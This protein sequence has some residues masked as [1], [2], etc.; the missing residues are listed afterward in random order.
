MSN[1]LWH[2]RLFTPKRGENTMENKHVYRLQGLSCA[3]CAA[4]FEKN[5]KSIATV[6]DAEVNF[7]A[8][9]LTVIGEAS[10][11]ELEK[12]GAF[13][14]ITVIPE[15]ERKEQKAEPFWKKKTNVI[16]MISALFLLAGYVAA[17]TIGE[18]HIATILS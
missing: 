14:G 5:V 6:K 15:T 16:V 1:S 18:R 17:Y 3:N 2:W 10:I 12:A 9:K 13:D 7:G 4:K 8:A 11:A